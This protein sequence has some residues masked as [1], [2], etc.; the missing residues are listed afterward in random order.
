MKDISLIDML[1]MSY[2]YCVSWLLNKYGPAL[3]NYFANEQCRSTP[4]QISRTDEG[5]QCHHIDE[6]KVA[7]LS[8]RGVAAKYSFEYQQKERLVYCNLL[9]HLI[10]HYKIVEEHYCDN[11]G[12]G[13]CGIFMISDNINTYFM[14]PPTK[15]SYHLNY[16][17]AIKD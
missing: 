17:N 7:N 6:N 8:E 12:L 11:P 5:L 3:C 13:I 16:Y 9:E 2:D 4:A 15:Q 14:T 10:L 1:S